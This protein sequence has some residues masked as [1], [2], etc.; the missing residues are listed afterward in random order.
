MHKNPIWLCFLSLVILLTVGYTGKTLWEV[1]GYLQLSS[2]TDASATAWSVRKEEEGVFVPVAKYTYSIRGTF[3]KG[4]TSFLSETANNSLAAEDVVQE[5]ATKMRTVWF[6][7][8]HP[9]YSSLEKKLP[10]KACIYAGI[11]W[12]L[13]VYFFWLGIYVG[14]IQQKRS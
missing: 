2:S 3:Y 13:C 7:P 10:L 9:E 5:L 12:A 8:K 11:L 14:N 6:S 1:Y 4:E